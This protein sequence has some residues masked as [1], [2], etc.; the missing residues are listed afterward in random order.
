MRVLAVLAVVL[1]L[2]GCS[3][4]AIVSTP[5]TI[6]LKYD[7]VLSSSGEAFEAAK[8]H[9]AQ[10]GRRAVPAAP[11]SGSTPISAHYETFLCMTD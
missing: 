6:T 2:G 10:Y 7:P 5:D 9:C 4:T 11:P 8:E 1:L 3:P